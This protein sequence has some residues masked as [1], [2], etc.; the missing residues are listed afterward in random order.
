MTLLLLTASLLA[1]FL[2]R[3]RPSLECALGVL[4]ALPAVNY[5]LTQVLAPSGFTTIAALG[6]CVLLGN[7]LTKPAQ[8]LLERNDNAWGALVR[9]LS[10]VAFYRLSL[11]WPDFISI[12]ERLRDY[13]ILAATIRNPLA[14][15][16]PWMTDTPLNYYVY[17]FRFGHAI[18]SIGAEEA[19]GVYHQM[20]AFALAAYLSCCFR[21]LKTHLS[22]PTKWA[23]LGSLITACGSNFAGIGSFLTRDTN[24]WGPSRVIPGAINEFP[25]WSFLLGDIHPHYL[26]LC[27]LPFLACASLLLVRRSWTPQALALSAL[28]WGPLAALWLYA[29]NAWELPALGMLGFW[30]I[31]ALAVD[32]LIR[33]G[34]GRGDLGDEMGSWFA[35]FRFTPRL[36]I[37]AASIIVMFLSLWLSTR[38]LQQPTK[39]SLEAVAF[40]ILQTSEFDMFRHWGV[41]LSLIAL[42]IVVAERNF[43]MAG[44]SAL[45]LIFASAVSENAVVPLALLVAILIFHRSS[46]HWAA[47]DSSETATSRADRILTSALPLAFLSLILFPEFFFIDDAYGGDIERMNTIFKFYSAAWWMSWI[48]AFLLLREAYKRLPASLTTTAAKAFPPPLAAAICTGF[49]LGFFVRTIPLRKTER[50]TIFPISMGLSVIDQRFP[51][52]AETIKRLQPLSEAVILEAQ[53]NAYDYTTHIATL[54][55]QQSFLGW[56]NHVGLLTGNYDE[57]RRREQ[58]T[59]QWYKEPDCAKRN[60]MLLEEHITDAVVG[61]LEN[62]KY[63]ATP[64]GAASCL[65]SRFT[66]GDYTVFSPKG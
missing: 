28:L 30:V 56:G 53:G 18:A 50:F 4:F 23:L 35:S 27:V 8:D 2:W 15:G 59:E 60:S 46:L 13:A 22:F 66:A 26:N 40:P 41:Q 11:L 54:S 16:E 42:S 24:W 44:A 21:L 45:I 51:G 3:R 12:G 48:G 47:A 14:P 33:L 36:A 61:P 43:V 19:W 64:P 5:L 31:A 57:V 55:G 38:H 6:I 37:G 9:L 39:F 1:F 49:L 29:A 7:W 34:H 32:T 52:S 63:G 17:W 10:Y 62:Q 25:A 58:F 65:T 20:A